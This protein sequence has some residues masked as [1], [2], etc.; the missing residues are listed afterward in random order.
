MQFKQR[1]KYENVLKILEWFDNDEGVEDSRIQTRKRNTRLC[2]RTKRFETWQLG[3]S[4]M[5]RYR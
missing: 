2:F 4:K 5:A 1:T 3:Q